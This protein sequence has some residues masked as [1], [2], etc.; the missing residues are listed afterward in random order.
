MRYAVP[1]INNIYVAHVNPEASVQNAKIFTVYLFIYKI[2][3]VYR[4]VKWDITRGNFES[5]ELHEEVEKKG[6]FLEYYL[7]KYSRG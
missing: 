1:T 7:D 4:L 2:E 5:N 6:N 3:S